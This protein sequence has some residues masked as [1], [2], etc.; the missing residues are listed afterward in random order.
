LIQVSGQLLQARQLACERDGRL[1]FRGLDL[2]IAP[3]DVIELMGPNGSGKSTLLRILAGL[4]PDYAGTVLRGGATAAGAK[5]MDM[6]TAASADCL[7][8]GH[9][10]GM[11]PGLAP[12]QNLQWFTTLLNGGG[13]SV[14]GIRAALARLLLSDARIWLL[15]EPATALDDAGAELLRSIIQDHRQSG[16]ATVVATHARLGVTA[17]L[18][19]LGS[20]DARA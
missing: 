6:D 1:L 15:D 18:M 20:G 9:R 2:D 3:G 11:S 7:Y 5:D 17:R 12:Q 8:L 16:G 4:M 14:T 19:L 10:T 13:A